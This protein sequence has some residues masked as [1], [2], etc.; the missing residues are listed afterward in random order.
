MERLFAEG[1]T[2]VKDGW[3][4]AAYY[5]C[6]RHNAECLEAYLRLAPPGIPLNAG[7]RYGICP[8]HGACR[9][10]KDDPRCLELLLAAG[11][12]P[13]LASRSGV[14][15]LMWAAGYGGVAKPRVESVLLSDPRVATV[16]HLSL[17]DGHFNRTAEE[18]A[19]TRGSEETASWIRTALKQAVST[20]AGF[21]GLSHSHGWWCR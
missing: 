9:G 11:A 8:V 7:N 5:L 12:D 3:C 2:G 1:A 10:E 17:R 16:D 13:T 21:R 4:G 14:T 19:V 6:Y 15:P 18:W 20:A